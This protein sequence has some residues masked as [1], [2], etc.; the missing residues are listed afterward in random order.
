MSPYLIHFTSG[1]NY[2][3]AC[4]TLQKIIKERRLI[5]G[6]GMI[7]GGYNC[8]C[9]S[10]AP[11]TNLTG[12]LVNHRAYSRYKPFGVLFHK[13]WIFSLGGRPV[14]YESDAEY[15]ALPVSHK[16]RHVLYRPD[17][18]DPIDFT[19]EREWRLRCDDLEFSSEY[20][21]IV[22]PND[23]WA[24]HLIREHD[25]EQDY[26]VMQYSL[27]FDDEQLAEM[28]RETWRWSVYSLGVSASA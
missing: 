8:V 6:S 25:T 4:Q 16:W 17:A 15:E 9:F 18:D 22:V 2:H 27:I 13:S 12:G 7:K 5:G 11:L 24:Q 19:W 3:F 20:A 28:H 14:I 26:I 1:E 23:E 10:E 21:S